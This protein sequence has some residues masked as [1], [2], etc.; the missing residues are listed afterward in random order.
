MIYYS[1]GGHTDENHFRC[2][3]ALHADSIAIG[4]LKVEVASLS[5]RVDSI[6]KMMP[7][8]MVLIVVAVGIP[9]VLVAWRSRKNRE[10]D[11]KIEELAREI[12][13]LKQQRIVS[14]K[15]HSI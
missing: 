12:E 6:D 1:S 13:T 11:R 15:Q 8:F 2:L 7:W 10:Q 9:Q 5:G 4:A 14:S 3:H